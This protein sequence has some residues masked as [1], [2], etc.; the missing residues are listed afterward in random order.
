MVLYERYENRGLKARIKVLKKGQG[1][2]IVDHFFAK[3]A[4]VLRLS[5]AKFEI[6]L[7]A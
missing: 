4:I 2:E 1:H 5:F 3:T 6:C 7:F